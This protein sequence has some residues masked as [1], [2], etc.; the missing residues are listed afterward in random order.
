[1]E[2]PVQTIRRRDLDE[3]QG[4]YAGSTSWLNIDHEW[5]KINV[6]ILEPD[7]YKRLFRNNIEGKDINTYKN[8]VVL[9]DITNIN[10]SMRDYSVTQNK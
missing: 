8:F 4:Q 1:M 2:Y 3:F 6:S 5:S 10:L 9:F 7:F